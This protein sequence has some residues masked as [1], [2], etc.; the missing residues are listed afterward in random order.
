MSAD[1]AVFT[2]SSLKG[3]VSY[4]LKDEDEESRPQVRSASRRDYGFGAIITLVLTE[5]MEEDE[6]RTEA[7]RGVNARDKRN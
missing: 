7:E 5:T 1:L 4:P 2:R 6:P 3:Q